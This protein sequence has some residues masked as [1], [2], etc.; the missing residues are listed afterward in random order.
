MTSKLSCR[1]GVDAVSVDFEKLGVPYCPHGPTI[2]FERFYSGQKSRSFYAC[3]VHRDKRYCPFFYWA[4][5]VTE[6]K[7]IRSKAEFESKRPHLNRQQLLRSLEATKESAFSVR[8]YCHTCER[9][10][11]KSDTQQ[12]EGHHVKEGVFDKELS[13]PTSIL[14]PLDNRKSQAQYYFSTSTVE[15][16][17]SE[18]R[19]LS[20]SRVLCVGAP[21]LHEAL[22]Q[23]DDITSMLL[24]IDHRYAQFYSQESYQ[25]ANM[26]NGFF[27]EEEGSQICQR[28]LQSCVEEPIAL[29]IDPPFGALAT[30]LAHGVKKL[31]AMAGKELP[32]VLVFPYF[33]ESHI[34]LA[35][36]SFKM[37][38]Y[39]V[40]YDN[41]QH[42]KAH[43]Q[44]HGGSKPSAVRIFTNLPPPGLVLPKEE[45]Y[46]FC[47]ICKRF[48][49]SYN[50][51]CPKCNSCPS[52]D[53]RL[54]VHCNKCST[55]VKPGLVHCV[56]CGTCKPLVHPA[57]GVTE[58]VGC[59]ICGAMDHKRRDCPNKDTK[60][61]TKK[62]KR[63]SLETTAT[64]KKKKAKH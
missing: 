26:F 61:T 45:G 42:F 58:V 6:E 62:Q 38:D 10:V 8:R 54:Y 32:T 24:D 40:T 47:S 12:H 25:C 43:M 35:L 55:C 9:L 57:C 33:M 15:F 51:H 2:L 20:Y 30:V 11:L 37:L 23:N 29:V 46:S 17:V 59:H 60:L 3:A 7:Q 53:G 5:E 48:V 39:Q 44:K 50:K 49:S 18:L 31:W 13:H 16:L 63:A 27:Y 14:T 28:F 4:D 34:T 22:L 21:R 52:K 1:Y 19:R 64:S 56:K 41:H 36:P